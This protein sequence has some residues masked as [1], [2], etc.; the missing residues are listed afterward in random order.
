M[1]PLGGIDLKVVVMS[2][3]TIISAMRNELLDA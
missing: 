1:F 2:L 3:K